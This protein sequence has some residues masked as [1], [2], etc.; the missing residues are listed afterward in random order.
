LVP[1]LAQGEEDLDPAKAEQY[2][3][4]RDLRKMQ[5][6]NGMAAKSRARR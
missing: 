1:L 6:E 5:E 3:R 2:K 4:W